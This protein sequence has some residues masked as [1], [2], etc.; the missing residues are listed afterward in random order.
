[1]TTSMMEIQ[2]DTRFIHPFCMMIAGPSQSG[3]TR[4]VAEMLSNV[5]KNIHPVV[6]NILHCYTTWQDSFELIKTQNNT[7]NFC[8][9]L[10]QMS[11]LENYKDMII[12]LDDLMSE[13]TDNLRMQYLFT[14][15]SHHNRIS[16]IF[17]TQ[18]IF[19]KG[20]YSR[21]ISL[22]SNYM[23]LFK[24]PRD[25]SQIACLARQI[26]PN[27][28]KYFTSAFNDA[29]TSQ[30]YGFLLVDLKQDTPDIVRLRTHDRT[31]NSTYV[32]LKR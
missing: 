10:P 16:V 13:C 12:V 27:N 15:G 14:V 3:K 1:M 26:F 2:F 25:P 8:E 4:F 24:N 7:I 30:N 19:C 31:T 21:T 18:N 11:E 20:K 17:L 22:N 32:Y 9:G 6:S 28:A 5:E 29:V 23:I